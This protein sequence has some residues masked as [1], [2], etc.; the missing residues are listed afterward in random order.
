MFICTLCN[1]AHFWKKCP[2]IFRAHTNFMKDIKENFSGP[3]T[4]VF[5]GSFGYPNVFSG[6]MLSIKEFNDKPSEWFGL[7]YKDIISFRSGVIRTMKKTHVVEKSKIQETIKDVSIS[8]YI[9]ELDVAFTKKPYM[10]AS[11]SNVIQPIVSSAN[12]K[13]I[14]ITSNLSVEKVVEKALDPEIKAVEA[15]KNMFDGGVDIY[16][17][18]NILSTGSLGI[19]KRL[20]PTR[21]S[22]TATDDILAKHMMEHIRDYKE[23]NDILLFSSNYLD[24]HFEILLLPG[25]WEYENFE[26]WMPASFSKEVKKQIIEHEYE[27]YS[28]R[29]KY[30][31][32]EAGGYYAARFS[33]TEYLS[34]IKKQAKAL[35][36]RE[37][38]SGYSIPVGVWLIRETV[39]NAMKNQPKRFDTIEECVIELKQRLKTEFTEYKKRSILLTQK[40]L[41]G[42]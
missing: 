23:I 7:P 42:F 28:G 9:P 34:K 36:I 40:N 39:R 38:H 8:K 27:P 21:Y 31:E 29:T 6:P 19:K 3:A 24:N 22:I 41:W 13:D 30:A 11:F 18:S 32:R 37:V 17:I 20:V 15:A 10:S 4:S 12:I 33:V 35:V 5:I 2:S 16:K 25:S 26:T 1:G 14:K